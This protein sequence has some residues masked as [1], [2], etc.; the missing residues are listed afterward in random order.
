MAQVLLAERLAALGAG[1]SVRSRG[2]LD[3]GRPARPEVIT[4]MAGYGW[5]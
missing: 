1:A 5:T 2:M 3:D 4:V